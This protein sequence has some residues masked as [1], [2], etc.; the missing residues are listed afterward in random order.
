MK[1][2]LLRFNLGST[3]GS[4]V[5]IGGSPISLPNPGRSGDPSH[6]PM[7]ASTKN[8]PQ[9]RKP[10]RVRCTRDTKM[11]LPIEILRKLRFL[12]RREIKR[13]HPP[14]FRMAGLLQITE[15]EE[16]HLAKAV[17]SA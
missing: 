4:R 14:S 1:T 5:E 8:Q 13:F 2:P 10:S 7:N 9:L 17:F 6:T 16:V 11:K 3:R 15:S 12:R